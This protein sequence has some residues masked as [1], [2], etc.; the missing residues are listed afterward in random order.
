YYTGYQAVN[1]DTGDRLNVYQDDGYLFVEIPPHSS[2]TYTIRFV[3]PWYWKVSYI[4][5]FFGAIVL[6]MAMVRSRRYG[7]ER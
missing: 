7:K 2:G 3:Q 1:K 5:S 4:V 6:I